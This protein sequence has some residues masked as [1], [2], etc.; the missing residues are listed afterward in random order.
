MDIVLHH[1]L[2]AM[3]MAWHVAPRVFLAW[4]LTAG[5]TVLVTAIV[6]HI[7][8]VSRL[9]GRAPLKLKKNPGDKPAG[10]SPQD[11]LRVSTT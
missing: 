3:P 6:L 8:I 2:P 11:D 9:F 4:F 1:I 5:A 7:P 10:R